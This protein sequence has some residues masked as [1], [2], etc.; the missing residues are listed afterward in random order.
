M[1][2]LGLIKMDPWLKPYENIISKRNSQF[3]SKLAELSSGSNSLIEF[4]SS[5]LYFGLHL[6]NNEWV[7]R[8]WAPN[9]NEI[10]MIGEFSDWND[11]E[12]FRLQPIGEG[13][14]EIRLPYDTLQ[15]GQLYKL[16]IYWPGGDGVRIPTHANRVVQDK[17]THIFSAEV[18]E[19][20]NRYIWINNKYE[21]KLEAPLIYEAH[22]GMSSEE[23]KINSFPEF[24]DEVLPRIKELG[25]NTIQLM[26]IQE[27]P[28][29]GSF[30]YHVSNFF[31]VSSR[32]GTPE[33]L[34]ELI[35]TAHGM[36]IKVIM[37]LVHSHAVKNEN[38]GLGKFDGTSYQFFHE[39]VKGDH[40]AWDSKCFNYNKNEVIHFLLSNCRYWLEEYRFDGFRFDG[41]TSMIYYNHGLGI[42]FSSYGDYF[43]E[44]EDENAIVYLTLA[45][46]LIHEINKNAISIAEEMSGY[47]GLAGNIED[48]GIGFD[49]RLSMGIPDFWIKIIKELADDNWSMGQIYHELT[50]HR[51]EEKIISYVESHDQALV[52]D[53]TVIFR[54]IDKEM[55]FYM[56]KSSENLIIDRGIALHKMIRLITL[57]TCWG[58]YL[59]FMGNEFGHP[60]WIDFPREGNNWS[61]H[62][63]KRQWSL[64]DNIDLKYHYLKDFDK[65]MIQNI[66]SKLTSLPGCFLINANEGDKI[67]TYSRGEFVFVFNFNPTKSYTNYGIG[68]ESGKYNLVL[69]SDRDNY[70]GFN[71]ID[72]SVIYYSEPLHKGSTNYQI[73]IYI[74]SR[75]AL[76]FRKIPTRKVY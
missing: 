73:K 25:Y 35:D 62:Y 34:K 41:V 2:E 9:A 56:N 65:D 61:Y 47:P 8:E 13:N 44:Q 67:L 74:P 70:G 26:A 3:K 54:L 10:F 40:P 32:F 28:Y 43:K 11:N 33:E 66:G 37:D 58:G 59:N 36:G 20:E 52:G 51:P 53:K 68:V 27:H 57:S 6:E 30:G 45:N 49:Y 72:D 7:F 55:Y 5:H 14:W 69:N 60:E 50:Q 15:H 42:D 24:K 29:Y 1:A 21:T 46:Y 4:S 12:K 17:E 48:G 22:V 16:H 38:E 31:A 71:R 23:G 63:A 18:W 39:G 76:V 19:P 75:V 64:A